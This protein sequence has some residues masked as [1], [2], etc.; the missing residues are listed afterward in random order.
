MQD[1]VNILTDCGL[2]AVYIG[3]DQSEETLKAIENGLF[4]YFFFHEN[5]LSRMEGG[6]ICFHRKYI[7]PNS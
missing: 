2:K 7:K 6:G 1:Q 5:P 3:G 4:T